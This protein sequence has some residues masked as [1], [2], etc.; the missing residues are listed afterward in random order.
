ML[1]V[2]IIGAGNIAKTVHIP[3]YIHHP[4]TEIVAISDVNQTSLDQTA[5][6]FQIEKKYLDYRQMIIEEKPDIVSV[7]TPNQFHGEQTLFALAH[8]CH[9]FCE[10][11]PAITFEEAK[12]M[13][14]S[15]KAHQ[16]SLGF[17]FHHRLR[18]D[19][20]VFKSW[21]NAQG[22]NNIYFCEVFALRR[23]GIPGWGV[24]TNKTLQGG[25]PLI[26]IGIHLL[27]LALFLLDFP[28]PTYVIAGMSDRIG[29]MGGVGDFGEWKG[30]DSFQVEDSLFG[31]ILFEN[32][33]IVQLQTAFAHHFAEKSKMD[34]QMYSAQ[35]SASLHPFRIFNET[36]LVESLEFASE[37]G[38]SALP[39]FIDHVMNHTNPETVLSQSVLWTQKIIDA[40]YL[41]ATQHRPVAVEPL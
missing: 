15:A 34:I 31:Q 4:N 2:A 36:G 12:A 37:P 30:Q 22:V 1:K 28:K 14:D 11:P 24:F 27:D 18:K 6:Q 40:L 19:A 38:L 17:N 16:L 21:I 33:L 26:D 3:A 41:S 39:G 29:K 13:H 10:K 25:G 20:Q 8:Q 7:C 32:G 35:S 23:R 9:V 5:H